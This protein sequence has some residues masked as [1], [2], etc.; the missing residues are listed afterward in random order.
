MKNIKNTVAAIMMAAVLLVGTG[1]AKT[2]LLMSDFAQENP[3]QCQQST[4]N[5]G[6][7][8]ADLT[9]IIIVGFTGIIIADLTA[10]N[11]GV[12]NQTSCRDGIIIAD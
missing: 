9:G 11:E 7:I 4:D 12:R 3:N 8:I 5:G 1:F 6:I 10:E 2:G